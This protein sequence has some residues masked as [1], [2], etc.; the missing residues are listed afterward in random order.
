MA[1]ILVLYGTTE[2]QTEK[3]AKAIAS[4]LSG[5][6]VDTDVVEAG[7]IDPDPRLYDGVIVAASVHVGAL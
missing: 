1:R 3:I 7:A 2:G 4:T 6:G 5:L